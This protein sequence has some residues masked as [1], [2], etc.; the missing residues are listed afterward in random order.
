MSEESP[1]LPIDL[2]HHHDGLGLTELCHVRAIDEPHPLNKA[3][4]HYALERRVVADE[5]AVRAKQLPH[6]RDDQGIIHVFAGQVQFQRGPRN[7][8]DSTPGVLDGCLL[9]ILIH[10]YETFQSGRFECPE[11]DIVLDHLKAALDAI[12]ARAVERAERGVLGKYE[13]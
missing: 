13:R 1:T 5:E 10:R 2:T 12:K 8:A 3:H 7:V 11:N 9:S 6:R 4:H